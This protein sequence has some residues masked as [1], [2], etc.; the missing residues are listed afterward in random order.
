MARKVTP[1]Q[2]RSLIRQAESKQR[3]AVQKYNQQV[4]QQH[5]KVRRAVDQYNTE[6]HKYNARVRTHRQRVLSQLNKLQSSSST[7][8]Y[9]ILRTS[10][11][12]LNERYNALESTGRELENTPFGAAF[13]D[14][15]EQ[16][17]ANSL[18]V[19]NV[20]EANDTISADITE[21]EL[22]RPEIFNELKA[23]SE[24]LESRWRGA[25]FSLNPNNPDAARHFCTSAREVFVRILDLHAPDSDVFAKTPTCETTDKGIPTRRAKIT[26][27][28]IRAGIYT[29]TAADFVDE[30]INNVLQLFRVFNDGTHGSAGHYEYG[31]LLAIKNRVEDGINY[32]LTISRP[33]FH[34]AFSQ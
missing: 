31:K 10:T 19:A 20:L 12:T 15:S 33:S 22:D 16:E 23:V 3:Q 29:E 25:L 21:D 27:L 4:R 7:V 2:L 26:Y 6:V 34:A 30:N 24:D 9:Q 32:L 14:L 8:R 28:L 18:E 5:Q 13:L 17:N 11:V 1:A